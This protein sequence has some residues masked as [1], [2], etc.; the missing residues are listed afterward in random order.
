MTGARGKVLVV[1]DD[2]FVRDMLRELLAQEG[3][4]Y[5]TAANGLEALDVCEDHP[6][7]SLIISDMNMPEMDGL[8][9]IRRL[10]ARGS[11]IPIMILTVNDEISVALSAL[12]SGASDYILKDEN[13]D[14]TLSVSIERVLEKHRL[15]MENIRLM[16]DLCQKNEALEAS[17]AE[18]TELN[19]LKNK[20]L[21]IAAHDLRTPISGVIGLSDI[22]ITKLAGSITP[23]H[24]ELLRMIN[25][26]SKEMLVLLDELLDVSM[27]EGG[28]LELRY[29]RASLGPLV[30]E[31]V[32][33]IE[34]MAGRK[35]I[36]IHT[37]LTDVPDTFLDANRLAQA[38]DNF[39]SNAIKFSPPGAAIHVYLDQ[40]G[41]MLRVRVADEGPGISEAEQDRLFGEFQKLTPRPTA[42]EMS[43]GLG[44][45]IVK[46]L[47]EA[48][49][50]L[51]GV[52]SRPG[53][54]A[55]FSFKVP[56]LDRAP[57]EAT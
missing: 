18:L 8:T 5:L 35:E 56:I 41:G 10:R 47:I 14:E 46:K 17:N 36:D 26:V 34:V 25:T 16:E 37:H 38:V 52:R 53:E 23:R 24:E 19:Q 43:T 6:D 42:G 57:E 28:K 29:N 21:G 1:D 44:L 45:A 33:L 55:V 50:G 30:A 20:F 4:P 3:Y 7:L 32:R 11:D 13:I 31:R 54:G 40:E 12:K 2:P 15:R 51:V 22:L 27:I 49:G 48:H 9:L 39:L